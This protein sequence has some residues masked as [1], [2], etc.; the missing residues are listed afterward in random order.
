MIGMKMMIS[1]IPKVGT[2]SGPGLALKKI[3]SLGK[4]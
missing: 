2:F 4:N 3:E 1:L